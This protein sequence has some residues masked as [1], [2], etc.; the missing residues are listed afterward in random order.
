M[1]KKQICKC[2]IKY[3]NE[4]QTLYGISNGEGFFLLEDGRIGR[5][6]G[7]NLEGQNNLT[8][9]SSYHQNSM[10]IVIP[11]AT[12][13]VP[14][15][16]RTIL[17]DK[18]A[19]FIKFFKV[20]NEMIASM[21]ALSGIESSLYSTK[22]EI[23][24]AQ[25]RLSPKEFVD[26]FKDNLSSEMKY[27]LEHQTQRGYCNDNDG[28]WEIKFEN[29]N[30]INI[31]ISRSIW[32]DKYIGEDK[33]DFTYR[34]YDGCL[35]INNR[36]T[37][38]YLKIINKY[39]KE[40]NCPDN[41]TFSECLYVGDKDSLSYYEYYRIPIDRNKPLTLELAKELANNFDGYLLEE[42]YER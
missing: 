35:M 39:H 23:D 8:F 20:R 6:Q 10:P 9:N 13:N 42:D 16:I 19:D 25:N 28:K 32:I 36:D 2:E 12:R 21:K 5:E 34:E 18:Y 4:T 40:L 38:D 3:Y 22:K 27:D 29:F 26:A 1:N 33:Y 14:P 24:K 15:E 31:K 11:S 7:C 17:E 41:I 37:S 30:S